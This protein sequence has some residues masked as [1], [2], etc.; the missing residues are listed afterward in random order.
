MLWPY[1]NQY[2]CCAFLDVEY[3][4]VRTSTVFTNIHYYKV[5]RWSWRYSATWSFNPSIDL[6]Q[7]KWRNVN[8]VGCR[9]YKRGMIYGCISPVTRVLASSTRQQRILRNAASHVHRNP[10]FGVFFRRVT[11]FRGQPFPFYPKK[12]PEWGVNNLINITPDLRNIR[13]CILPKLLH[14]FPWNYA[15]QKKLLSGFRDWS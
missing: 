2:V 11:L 12:T 5:C 14:R 15:W 13:I 4:K 10:A 3:A 1:W 7:T 8:N 6:F 9:K